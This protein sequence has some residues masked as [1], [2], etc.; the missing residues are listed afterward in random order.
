[1]TIANC[2]GRGIPFVRWRPVQW[3]R[4]RVLSSISEKISTGIFKKKN[5]RGNKNQREGAQCGYNG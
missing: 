3:S 4:S 1:M 2:W 5:V